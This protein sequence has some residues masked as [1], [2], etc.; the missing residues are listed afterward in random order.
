MND[1]A[2]DVTW[3]LRERRAPSRTHPDYLGSSAFVRTLRVLLQN[4]ITDRSNL[5]DVLDV[6]C[7]SKPFYPIL[8]KFA[9]RYIGTE[10]CAPGMNTDVVCTAEALAIRDKSQDLVICFSVLEHVHN[11]DMVLKELYRVLRPGGRVIL[12]TH[13]CFPWHPS[14]HDHW[15][16]T[17]TGLPLQFSRSANFIEI[18]IFPTRG[19]VSG[20]FFLLAHYA[21]RGLSQSRIRRLFRG[22]TTFLLNSVGELID[23]M[24]PSLKD[25]T[26]PV[27]AIPEF[28]VVAQRGS[29]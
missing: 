19:T 23:Y 20:V 18:K 24:T 11:P 3:P 2:L 21:Y 13:G 8:A 28:I 22:A 9:R 7:G 5:L 1:E 25:P 29:N 17:Q 4:E 12:S 15:R 27:T 26:Q 10:I 14:P 6:G 16:W